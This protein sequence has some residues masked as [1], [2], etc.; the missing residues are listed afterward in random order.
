[1]KK[2]LI[3]FLLSLAF[4]IAG[5]LT[6]SDY[7]INWDMPGHMLRGLAYA[8]FIQ[9]GQKPF[10]QP[11]TPS[12][13]F[14]NS[15]EHASRFHFAAIESP[16]NQINPNIAPLSFLHSDKRTS[17]YQHNFFNANYFLNDFGHLS[18][19]DTLGGFSNKF[20]YQTLGILG[21]IASFQVVYLLLS[22]LG[23]FIVSQFTYQLT[24]SYFAAILAG[25]SLGLYPLFFGDSHINA[26][27]PIQ[28][29]FFAG[30]V[31]AFWNWVSTNKVRWLI[32]FSCF[33]AFAL[34]TKWNIIFLPM[35]MSPWLF[36]IKNTSEFKAWFKLKKLL[37]LV[38]LAIVLIGIILIVITAPD[39]LFNPVTRAINTFKFYLELGTGLKPIQ[40]PGFILPL[41]F[42][43]Y[44][45][46]LLITQTP[47][48]ILVLG[49][50]G[51]FGV[52]REKKDNLKSAYLLLI[53]L[54]IP[55]IRIS[56]PNVFSYGGIRQIMEVLPA[57][58]ILAGIGADYLLKKINIKIINFII[59]IIIILTLAFPIIRLHPNEN[60]YFNSF[61]GG[62][63][64]AYQKNLLDWTQ[65]Y[66]NIYKQAILWLD[67]N[68]EK[69]AKI[70]HLS[71]TDYAISPLWFREDI[72]ISPSLFSGFERSGEYILSLYDPLNPA[73]FAYRYPEKFL[74][75]I[76]QIEIEGVPLLTIFK[77]DPKFLRAGFEKEAKILNVQAKIIKGEKRDFMQ[78]DLGKSLKVTRL[79]V[80]GADQ[81]CAIGADQNDWVLLD[82]SN[83]FTTNE[84]KA[85]EDNQVEFLFPAELTR[86]IQIFPQSE[87]SCFIK[88][89][90]LSVS[91]ISH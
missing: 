11:E 23:I 15:S 18:T 72:T 36:L 8:N 91:F 26:K 61:A 4:F 58:A 17:F 87:N 57:M 21:Q 83:L 88:G 64:G 41:G 9:T 62:L 90:V 2:Y 50:L 85:L 30:S 54:L 46:V 74:I 77:N 7:G 86:F 47:G 70:A 82:S 10:S 28:A 13:V 78:I 35:I 16:A 45:L 34:A 75:P 51:M 71:G 63:K 20:F 76:H 89:R 84:I 79:R 48:I 55:L 1:M 40:S 44:P 42:N 32:L 53:W 69:D 33:I 14:I 31:W 3:P 81:K 65:T 43:I 22:A 38:S 56:L 68:G 37:I 60:V 29:S 12:P 59:I 49:G 80:I 19:V 24:N 25:L 73:V 5:L 27:D 39:F 66:G 6:L 52:F 67:K